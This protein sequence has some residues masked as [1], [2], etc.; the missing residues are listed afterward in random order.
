[1]ATGYYNLQIGF[2]SLVVALILQQLILQYPQL[3]QSREKSLCLVWSGS[4]GHQ[5]SL[6]MKLK[7][8]HKG[9]LLKIVAK[10]SY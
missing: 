3:L 1:M 8:K 5:Q 4:I 2:W 6:Q 10:N 7:K 9:K